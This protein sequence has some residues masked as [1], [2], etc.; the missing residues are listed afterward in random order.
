MK[1]RQE[2]DD[3]ICALTATELRILK[4]RAQSRVRRLGRRATG[5]DWADL[6]QEAVVRTI[7]GDRPCKD[8]VSLFQHL[9]GAIQSIAWMWRESYK[10]ELLECEL[11]GCGETSPVE[12]FARPADQDKVAEVNEA[13]LKI[14]IAFEAD[15]IASQ[16]INLLP[17]GFTAEEIQAGLGLSKNEQGAVAKRILRNARKILS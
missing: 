5:R 8:D 4:H 15:I 13:L 6:L 11:A 1:S 10:N 16:V 17:L 7:A 9:L 14:K 12:Q 3:A 2:V